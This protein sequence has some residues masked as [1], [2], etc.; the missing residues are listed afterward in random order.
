MELGRGRCT[1]R[2][3]GVSKWSKRQKVCLF[4]FVGCLIL[5]AADFFGIGI[6]RGHGHTEWGVIWLLLA[7]VNLM[8]VLYGPK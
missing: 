5:G 6:T 3:I 8:G 4:T 7:G 1:A 2:S